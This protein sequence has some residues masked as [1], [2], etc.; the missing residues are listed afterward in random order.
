MIMINRFE[1]KSLESRSI[2]DPAGCHQSLN[3]LTG[4]GSRE[5]KCIHNSLPSLL[6][7]GGIA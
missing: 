5:D 3:T 7:V 2:E 1:N 6:V 4:S